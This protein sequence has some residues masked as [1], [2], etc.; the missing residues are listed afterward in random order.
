M[1]DKQMKMARALVEQHIEAYGYVPHPDKLKEAI[2]AQLRA[3]WNA[4]I[5]ASEKAVLHVVDRRPDFMEPGEISQ[6]LGRRSR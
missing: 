3:H 6:F 5:D 2:A 4:A 1:D